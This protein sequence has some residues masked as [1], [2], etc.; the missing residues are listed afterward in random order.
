MN[1]IKINKKSH[2]CNSDVE[3]V[4]NNKTNTDL[5]I[6]TSCRCFC[7]AKSSTPLDMPEG[8]DEIFGG[9]KK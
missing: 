6:C 5:Y 2:C 1:K 4:K 9:F 7:V 8:F 3:I